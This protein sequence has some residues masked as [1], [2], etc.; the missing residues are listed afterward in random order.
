MKSGNFEKGMKFLN[1][2]VEIDPEKY[3]GS[4]APT[5]ITKN[6]EAGYDYLK[7]A[8]DQFEKNLK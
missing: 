6:V 3:K 2:A 4:K 1:K 8:Y 7:W 5:I